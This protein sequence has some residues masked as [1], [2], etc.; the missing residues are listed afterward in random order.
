MIKTMFAML[1]PAFGDFFTFYGGGSSSSK[2]TSTTTPWS[3]VQPY[4]KDYL[5][6]GQQQSQT[7][8]QFYSGDQTAPFSPEQQMGLGMQTQRA[9]QGAPV[10]LAAQQ[11]LQGTLSGQYMNA[12]PWQ[13]Q[14]IDQA[15]N[16]VTGQINSRFGG[17]NFGGSANQEMLTRGLASTATGMYTQPYAQERAR[18][19]QAATLAPAAAATDYQDIQALTGVG[20]IRRQQ[21]QDYL[22]QASGLYN[23]YTQYPAQQLDAYGNIVRTGMGGGQS[24]MSTAP[25]PYQSNPAATALGLASAGAGLYNQFGGGGGNLQAPGSGVNLSPYASSIWGN[26]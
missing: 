7:P 16:D 17:A 18:Q 19:L 22:N 23:Q 10:N 1:C 15:L 3:G 25:N 8:F 13:Q 9:I 5:Q 20:D 2:T 11:N 6:Q 4:L 21:A 26:V 12:N 24:S 14:N